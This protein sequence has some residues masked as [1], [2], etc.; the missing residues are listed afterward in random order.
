VHV[1]FVGVVTKDTIHNNANLTIVEPAL[2]TEPSFRS[3]GGR[4][5]E[6]YGGDANAQGDE[7]L[8]EEE[9]GT[10]QYLRA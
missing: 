9:P 8:D 3:H 1:A 6:E 5:H 2:G 10:H 7:T 4:W